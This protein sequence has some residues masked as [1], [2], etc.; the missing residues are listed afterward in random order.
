MCPAQTENVR[1]DGP[2]SAQ[3]WIDAHNI[4]RCMHDVPALSWSSV[5]YD[6][7]KQT[8][9]D[10]ETM[11]H[12]PSYNVPPPAGPQSGIYDST[13]DGMLVRRTFDD[14]FSVASTPNVECGNKFVIYFFPFFSVDLDIFFSEFE[15]QQKFEKFQLAV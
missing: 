6:H 4:R 9:R 10:Q 5:M 1:E 3:A 11:K 15:F 8:F 12:S 7:V 13:G 14:S 2:G